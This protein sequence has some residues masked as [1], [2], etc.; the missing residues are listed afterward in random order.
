[1]VLPAPAKML[2]IAWVFY[3]LMACLWQVAERH[4]R[5]RAGIRGA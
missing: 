4:Y 1:M 3:P 5:T 2:A